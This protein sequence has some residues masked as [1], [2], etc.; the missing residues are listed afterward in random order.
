MPRYPRRKSGP[1][2]VAPPLLGPA[3]DIMIAP[4]ATSYL[5]TA[6]ST[7]YEWAARADDPTRAANGLPNPI[8]VIRVGR[9]L[10]FRRVDLD[11]WL[12]S[13]SSSAKGIKVTK[14]GAR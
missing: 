14:A 9:L 8:P 1:Y 13:R 7:V 6:P 2:K 5:R 3:P 10:R 12:E 11:A 4:E